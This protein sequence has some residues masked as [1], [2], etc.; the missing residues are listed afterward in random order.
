MVTDTMVLASPVSCSRKRLLV[1]LSAQSAFHHVVILREVFIHCLPLVH[2]QRQSCCVL[3]LIRRFTVV[4][5]LHLFLLVLLYQF[6][7]QYNDLLVSH[8]V[9]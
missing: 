8:L 4:I 2:L 7:H 5:F 9:G 3:L 1:P 6:L